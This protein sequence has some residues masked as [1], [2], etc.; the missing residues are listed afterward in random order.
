MKIYDT[1]MEMPVKKV[2]IVVVCAVII[3]IFLVQALF[4]NQVFSIIN[5]NITHFDQLF[6]QDEIEHNKDL[7]EFD[8]HHAYDMQMSA[9][10]D[11]QFHMTNFAPHQ[12]RGCYFLKNIKRFEAMQAMAYVKHTET[13]RHLVEFELKES[14]D[15]LKVALE[16]HEFDPALCKP[17]VL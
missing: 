13:A 9:H 1:I 5:R 7:R 11:E 4:V 6:K 14:R 16:K 2:A 3:L 17:V 10:N 8:E 12:E 15:A